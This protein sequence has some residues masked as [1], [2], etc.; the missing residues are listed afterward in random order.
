[1]SA[2][3]RTEVH[4]IHTSERRSFRACRRRWDWIFQ[5]NYY[6][7]MTAKPL[8]FGVA[9]HEAMEV[10]YNPTTWFMDAETKGELA[11]AAF[12]RKVEEQR[13]KFL[14]QGE[15]SYLENE[16]QEDYDER[17]TLGKGMIKYHAERVSPRYDTKWTPVRVE[18]SFQ[19]P[20]THPDT[21]AP[22]TCS[23]P[24]C[25]HPA[26]A[27]VVYAGRMDALGEDENG[28]YWVIDWKTA[29]SLSVNDEFLYLDDQIGSYVWAC[30][31]LGL[32]VRG[33][34]YHEMKKGFPEWPTKNKVRRLGC[35]FSKN[36]QQNTSY[37]MY[38]E[39][40]K[41]ED[42]EAYN[43]GLYD[44]ML[45]FLE[46]EG[47]IYVQR[48]Q[49]HKS[50]AELE[51]IARNIGLEALDMIDPNTR[52]YPSPGRFGCTFCAFRTPCMGQ[53]NREDYVYALNTLF[54]RREHYYVREEASTDSKS[55]E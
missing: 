53:N 28:D 35:I 20:I 40:V 15:I 26:G 42:E 16:V 3:A 23:N 8:E 27:P 1:L 50:P 4:E 47:S 37:D 24:I 44:D 2:L 10:F 41:A 14:S 25:R 17:V 18:V 34:V 7:L 31:V 39:A 54:E 9:Y 46:D 22:L 45:K 30:N 13:K 6:P 38:L 52:I 11:T 48:F 32:P 36:K 5:Q 51:E 55:A 12:V 21:G 43:E 49:I 29:R 19:V 33:F